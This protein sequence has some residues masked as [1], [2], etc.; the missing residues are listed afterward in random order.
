MSAARLSHQIKSIQVDRGQ[1]SKRRITDTKRSASPTPTNRLTG[2]TTA[3]PAMGDLMT[4]KEAADRLRM[5]IKSIDRLVAS[6]K[7]ICYRVGGGRTRRFKVVDIER[8]LIPQVSRS[9]VADDLRDFIAS[10]V[11]PASKGR[12]YA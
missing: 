12:P 6:G 4:A 7:L 1:R 3:A 8:Q 10:K 2:A 5:C 9:Q 11:R